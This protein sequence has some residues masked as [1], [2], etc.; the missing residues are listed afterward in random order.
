MSAPTL[1]LLDCRQLPLHP[2]RPDEVVVPPPL[3]ALDRHT[4][5]SWG[6]GLSLDQYLGRERQLRASAFSRRR[7][8]TW[9]LCDGDS[10]SAAILAT[11]ETYAVEL[12][13]GDKPGVGH[14]IATVFVEPAR[15]GHGYASQLLTLLHAELQK[16]G[17]LA[18]YLFSEIGPALYQRLGY[19]ER[20]LS[21]R[22]YAAAEP[23]ESHGPTPPW[24]LLSD[25]DLAPALQA[26]HCP[27]QPLRFALHADQ[28]LWHVA[29]SRFYAALLGQPPLRAVGAR[30]RGG[31]ALVL[32]APEYRVGKGGP[33]GV[34]RLLLLYPGA[35]LAAAGAS[36]DPRSDDAAALRNVLH[37][38][39][40]VACDLGL[41]AIELW[42]NP[43]NAGYLRGGVRTDS[44]D[45]P[46]LR[47][48]Q[49]GL[50]GKDWLDYERVH[51]L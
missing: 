44:P 48:L 18:S 28:V 39:R 15:R 27:A 23:G 31:D 7:L 6:D 36:F 9:L 14:G 32:W 1:R 24:Q 50:R 34:L 43:Q 4:Y 30:V 38:A 25:D 49:P 45:L 41:P 16:E 11:C 26:R 22:R 37:A 47:P 40:A 2:Q 29:R 8:R 20:P 19:V 13:A 46:M 3:D 35:R 33:G 51:W 5:A 21:L 10:P 12:F 42:E 17:A